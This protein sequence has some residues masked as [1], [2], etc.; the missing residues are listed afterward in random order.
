MSSLVLQPLMRELQDVS[1]LVAANHPHFNHN[2]IFLPIEG[3][4]D[5][6]LQWLRSATTK[7]PH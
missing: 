1:A 7:A 6:Y 3:G 4:S 2:I 5:P